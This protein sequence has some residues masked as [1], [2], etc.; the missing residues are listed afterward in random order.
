[1]ELLT[2]VIIMLVFFTC[3]WLTTLPLDGE[4]I[5]HAKRRTRD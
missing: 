4:N 5:N 2:I 1:M 3:H